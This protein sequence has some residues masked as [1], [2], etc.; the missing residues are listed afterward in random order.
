MPKHVVN[1]SCQLHEPGPPLKRFS[2]ALHKWRGSAVSLSRNRSSWSSISRTSS[3][4]PLDLDDVIVEFS[5]EPL[6]VASDA[7]QEGQL[8][9]CFDGSLT[10]PSRRTVAL[11]V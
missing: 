10:H 1:D 9:A 11:L 4:P 8:G 7:V 5:P 3:T 6:N 2:A